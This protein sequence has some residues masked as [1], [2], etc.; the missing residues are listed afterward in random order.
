[1][2]ETK[3]R[4]ESPKAFAIVQPAAGK[5]LP[6]WSRS[7]VD[8]DMVRRFAPKSGRRNSGARDRRLLNRLECPVTKTLEEVQFGDELREVDF[9]SLHRNVA[10]AILESPQ[11]VQNHVIGAL[12]INLQI[13]RNSM[14]VKHFSKIDSANLDLD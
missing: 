2:V 12:D 4:S 8:E 10:W 6:K 1:M 5:V 7:A 13:E 14:C 9:F 3:D 11:L